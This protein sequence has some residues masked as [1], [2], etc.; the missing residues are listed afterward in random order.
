MAE[1]IRKNNVTA[2]VDATHPFA[3]VIS[4]NAINAAKATGIPLLALARPAWQPEIGDQWKEVPHHRAAIAALGEK[5]R[6]VFMTVGRLEVDKYA[7]A[8]QHFYI[9]R[10]I[11]PVEPKPLPNAIWLTQ[12]GPFTVEHEHELLTTHKADIVV[13][14]NSGGDAM[15]SKLIAARQLKLPVILIARP[16]KPGVETVSL[17]KDAMQWLKRVHTASL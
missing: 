8:P 1:W 11:E 12:R 15:K 4:T 14:K 7:A 17:P 5:P 13:T 2:L 6:R 16:P 3:S 9:A 10:T